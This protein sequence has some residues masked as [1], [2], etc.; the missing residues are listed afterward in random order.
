VQATDGTGV[1]T[2]A[3][4]VPGQDVI[5][6]TSINDE[7]AKAKFGELDIKFPY[8]RFVKDPKK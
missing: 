4:W 1:A 2:P 5:V 8:L 7:A 3:N 6:S